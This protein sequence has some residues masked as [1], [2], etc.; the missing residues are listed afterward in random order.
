MIQ[1]GTRR[2]RSRLQE[3]HP[4]GALRRGCSSAQSAG[5]DG[6]RHMR[7]V[8]CSESS[9]TSKRDADSGEGSR[10]QTRRRLSE[11]RMITLDIEAI[12]MRE[13]EREG[14][15]RGCRGEKEMGNEKE[16]QK[17]VRA[18][19]LLSGLSAR[20]PVGPVALGTDCEAR[21]RLWSHSMFQQGT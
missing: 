13:R 6:R 20:W 8:A 5:A 15:G 17:R 10:R 21:T 18:K 1:R 12:S 3:S 19:S 2:R 16:E 7:C 4:E 14:A 11:L 9:A